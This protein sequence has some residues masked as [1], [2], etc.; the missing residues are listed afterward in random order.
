MHMLP[1]FPDARLNAMNSGPTLSIIPEDLFTM[2]TNR[3]RTF[4]QTPKPEISI[5][6]QSRKKTYTTLDRIEGFVTITAPVDTDFDSIDVEF[7]G[8]SRTHVERYTTAAAASGRQEA[9]Q[10]FLKLS[11]PGMQQSYPEGQTLKAGV[12][13]HFPFVF[14]VP[15][16]LL[17]RSCQH[18]VENDVIRDAHYRLPPSLG[19]KELSAGQKTM[20]DMAPEMASVR[21]GI[22]AKVTEVKMRGDDCWRS[23]LSS[24]A[25]RVRVVP[26]SEEHPPLDVHADDGEYTM[27]REKAI[28]KGMLKGKLGTLTMEAHQPQAVNVR[29]YDN[30]EARTD[31]M[32]TIALRFDPLNAASL[33]PK[34]GSLCSK[35][36]VNT[37]FS[38]TARRA[39]P[40]KARSLMDLTQGLHSEYLNLSS[41]CV[42]NVE[43]KKHDPS[44]PEALQRRDSATSLTTGDTGA[45][46]IPDPSES[47]KGGEYYTAHVLVPLQLPKNRAFVPTFHSCLISRTY[48]VKLELSTSSV[49]PGG[50][51]VL[52]LPL[53]ISTEGFQ[54]DDLERR[55]SMSATGVDVDVEDVSGFF[56]N[57]MEPRTTLVSARAASAA[58]EE[59]GPRRGSAAPSY[60]A[61]PEEP[62]GYSAFAGHSAPRMTHRRAM[63]VPVF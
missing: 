2:P 43:W 9:F 34:L 35:L 63:S 17:L 50:N 13:Y 19:D 23:T 46:T 45:T 29:S 11:Q 26:I 12:P 44:K 39:V 56:Q 33:P 41:R 59:G 22:F 40:T 49:G 57:A 38:S 53:Q 24:K 5:T 47:Y 42:A 31:S 54:G 55:E 16:Q 27:R 6:F 32:A 52:K 48:I 10:Q 30:P 37:Y 15:Q 21:Y 7:V 1:G 61:P 51:L 8:T 14:A 62:P 4:V 20:D 18:G 36:K 25:R 28:K 3:L 58:V 60:A